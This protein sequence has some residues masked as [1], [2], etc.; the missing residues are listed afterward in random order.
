MSNRCGNCARYPF[1]NK[2][3]NINYYCSEWT[4]LFGLCVNCLGCN[5]LEDENFKGTYRCK[6]WRS[7]N[8][9]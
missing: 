6:N 9:L 3:V 7:T 5:K 8:E 2:I 4:E 1:C